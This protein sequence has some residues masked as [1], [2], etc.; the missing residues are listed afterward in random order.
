M[1][2]EQ[3]ISGNYINREYSWMMFNER[4]LDQAQDMTNPLLE[5]CK[6]LSIFTSNLDEFFMVRVGSLYNQSVVSP[7]AKENKTKLTAEKQIDGILEESKRLYKR[8]RAVADALKK[9][10]NEVAGVK[11]IHPKQMSAKQKLEAGR[12]FSARVM[13]YLSPMVLDIKHPMIR[14]ESMHVYFIYVLS[15]GDREMFG[16]LP[17]PSR[18]SR[19]YRFESGGKSVLMTIEDMVGAFGP[20]AFPGYTVKEGAMIRVTRNADFETNESDVDS[21]YDYDFAK[22]M[23]DK[24]S[25]RASLNVVRLEMNN[26]AETVRSFLLK[27]LGIKK[28]QCFVVEDWFD[29]KFMF[30]LADYI[31]PELVP[32]LKYPPFK[33]RRRSCDS[34]IARVFE[35]DMFLAYPY[36]SMDT[37][38]ALLEECA[39]DKR[40]TAI[41]ITIYR[42]DDHSRVAEALKRAAENGVDVTVVIELCARFDEENNMYYAQELSD[43]G[44]SVIYGMGNYKVHSKIVSVVFNDNGAVRYI[45]HLGT[46]NYNEGTSRQYTD[47]NVITAD[48]GIGEDGAAF[49]RALSVISEDFDCHRL[50]VAPSTLKSGLLACMDREIEKARAG[51]SAE[52]V[53]KMNSLTDKDMIDKLIEASL[54]GVTV[55]LVVRG[56]CCLLPGGEQTKNIRVVSIVGRFLEHSRI[57]SFG[58]GTDRVMYISS[59]DL[60][61]RNTGKRVEIATPILDKGIQARIYSMLEVMLA[62]NVKGRELKNDGKYY[63][64]A[65]KEN[66]VNSQEYFLRTITK[67]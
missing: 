29:Y 49:F 60:M 27:N 7:T 19:L 50:L 52:I 6:F 43:A 30:K 4:V 10:L 33:G 63:A 65:D 64:P 28:S 36:D 1:D 48:K 57:Y 25:S 38:V 23:R 15:K 58:T 5:R 32:A 37:L 61:T 3:F 54:A 55:K 21:E 67:A 56:I 12:F 34:L 40:V 22:Y 26:A 17:V 66:P 18:L 11:L 51:L 62:D 39:A 41:R 20:L 16:V 31:P 24:I 53:A 46:G 59:A 42:L 8:K 35:K 45:T 13:P 44:C 2:R 14:F 47:L 9:E